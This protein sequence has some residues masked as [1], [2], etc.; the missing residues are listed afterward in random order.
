MHPFLEELR[1]RRFIEWVLA[2][3]AGAVLLL[4]VV[5]AFGATWGL[6][7][8]AA[9]GIDVS[10]GIGFVFAVVLSWYHGARGRQEP[11]GPELLILTLL[12]LLASLALALV[13]DEP[14]LVP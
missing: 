2:Y 10:L 1:K 14:F 6:S 3:V 8:S 5:D 9:R 11:T 4:E 13:V 7:T 12:L